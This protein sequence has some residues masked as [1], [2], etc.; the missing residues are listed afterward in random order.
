MTLIGLVDGRFRIEQRCAS[1][2]MGSVY[3]ARDLSTGARVALKV[4]GDP[5]SQGRFDREA[6]VLARLEH[7]GIVRYIAHG[8]NSGLSY[9]VMEWLD[10]E[11]LRERLI[12]TGLTARQ[13]VAMAIHVCEALA[14]AHRHGVVHRDVKPSNLLFTG[15]GVESVKL[16]DFGIVRVTGQAERLTASG[17]SIGTPGYM[18]PEQVRSH[19]EVELRADVFALGCVLYECLTGRRAFPGADVKTVTLK[20]VLAQPASMRSVRSDL[21]AALEEVVHAMLAKDAWDRPSAEEV[22]RRLASIERLPDTRPPRSTSEDGP[23]VTIADNRPPSAVAQRGAVAAP[24]RDS[25]SLVIVAPIDDESG[26]AP[27][28]LTP[29]AALGERHGGR[30]ETLADRSLLVT[31]VGPDGTEMSIRAASFALELR[32]SC[33]QAVITLASALDEGAGESSIELAIER[34]LR[35]LD[36]ALDELMAPDAGAG[37][38]I[39]HVDETAA[40][41]LRDRFEIE[42]SLSGYHLLSRRRD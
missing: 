12:R 2:G 28:D 37:E 15:D 33:D 18:A 38:A 36:G 22:A 17:A 27:L 7:P 42:A 30:V 23:T 13:S 6:E 26:T 11:T 1:G 14:A 32:K 21:P 3:R 10:G 39:V 8:A 19:R 4:N 34:G 16:I 5:A 41:L 20:I 40:R 31:F 29:F 35:I 24:R 25:V 9:L